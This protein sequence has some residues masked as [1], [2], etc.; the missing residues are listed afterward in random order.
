MFSVM[1]AQVKHRDR[2]AMR[3]NAGTGNVFSA[4]AFCYSAG[5]PGL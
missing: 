2:A 5:V 3:R 4:R 1:R